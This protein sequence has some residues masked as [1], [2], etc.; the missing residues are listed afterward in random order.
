M[1]KRIHYISLLFCI[2]GGIMLSIIQSIGLHGLEGY[3]INVEV[4]VSARTSE[5]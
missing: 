2:I 4:D 1:K 5:L 3:L